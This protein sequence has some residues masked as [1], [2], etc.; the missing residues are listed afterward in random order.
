MSI[1]P[2]YPVQQPQP[3]P[4]LTQQ[5][6]WAPP[7]AYPQQPQYQQ[8]A[9][10]PQP[11]YQQ[12]PQ[13]F[14]PMQVRLSGPNI[15]R[16]LQGRTMQE[17][18]QYYNIM[19]EDFIRRE[20]AKVQGQQQQQPQQPQ[21]QQGSAQPRTGY[22][23]PQGQGQNGQDPMRQFVQDAVR[24]VMPEMLAPVIIPQQQRTMQETYVRTAQ[25]F[26][27]WQQ[28]DAEI[29]SSLQGADANVLSNPA[30]WEAAYFHAKGKAT[31]PRRLQ[32]PQ[33]QPQYQSQQYQGG[34]VPPMPQNY[35]QQQQNFQQPQPQQQFQQ[36][37]AFVEGPT[38][39]APTHGGPGGIV[40]PRDEIFA[41][42]FNMPVEVYRAGKA[43][44]G[45]TE[46]PIPPLRIPQQQFN[47]GPQAPQ[48]QTY[49]PPPQNFQPYGYAPLPPIGP[50]GQPIPPG[51]YNPN[52]NNG[53][54]GYG[55]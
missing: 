11:Q 17:G 42:R 15:P 35:P 27:D 19:R 2:M 49:Q 21:P 8:P 13:Q 31:D 1:P 41:R 3:Q 4:I 52:F 20:Q 25:Q 40:D 46:A 12:T 14:D 38:P 23:P 24:E 16:E 50:N 34:S 37:S 30:A 47:G 28:F 32:Q 53:V 22:Q 7:S 36:P 9:P 26:P 10:Q 44:P 18:L 45:S 43:R 6:G 33:P 51:F 29:R 39:A 55:Y 5:P 48:Q 54:S